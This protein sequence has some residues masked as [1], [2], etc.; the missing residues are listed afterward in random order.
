MNE[1]KG[2]L[3]FV[4]GENKF[5]QKP[6][7]VFSFVARKLVLWPQRPRY[8][9][10]T[11]TMHCGKGGVTLWWEGESLLKG[12]IKPEPRSSVSKAAAK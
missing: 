4:P 3:S 7:G 9:A 5:S 11:I 6:I 12:L 2:L 10:A 1:T 8:F